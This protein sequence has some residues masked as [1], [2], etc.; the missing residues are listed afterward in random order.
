MQV[1][2]RACLLRIFVGESDRWQ[3]APLFEALVMRARMA[4]LAGAT[5]MRC[6]MGF[7][8][9][10][11]LHTAR[12]LRL[13]E[14]LP[15]VIDIVDARE[16]IEAFLPVVEEMVEHGLVTLE[17]VEVIRYGARGNAGPEV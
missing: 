17:D 5:V 3:G 12:I 9:S 10:S 15:I 16:K 8:A 2:R 7:G 6:P 11:R 14:D 4:H 1:P 13:S